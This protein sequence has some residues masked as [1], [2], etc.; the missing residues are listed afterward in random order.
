MGLFKY[1]VFTVMTPDLTVDDVP[2]VLSELG[3]EGIEWRVAEVP[4]E[5]KEINYWTGN[6]ATLDFARILEEARRAKKLCDD[7]DIKIVALGTY[8]RCDSNRR[9]IERAL[10]AAQIMECPQIRV[11]VPR[12]DGSVNY[13]ELFAKAVKEYRDVE[14]LAKKYGVRCNIEIHM[15]T[16]CPSASATYR[17]VSNFDPEY[18]GVIYD[19]GN[20]M[21]EGYENWQMGLE[22]L[23]PY[24]AHVHVKNA[25]WYIVGEEHGAKVWKSMHCPLREGMVNWRDVLKALKRVGYKGW[26]SFEDFSSGDTIAKLR[27][28]IKFMRQLEETI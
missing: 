4:S 16:I 22:L 26:L 21:H 15:R 8:L 27:D 18:V 20:M 25:C 17:L 13:N 3:Y 5:I 2:K 19:P 7:Y 14:K 11:G 24:L 9:D 10:K 23:G 28:N 1:S 6:R 12:Y